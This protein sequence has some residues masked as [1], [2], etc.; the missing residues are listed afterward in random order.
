MAEPGAPENGV[1]A[2]L[3]AALL[4]V[5]VGILAIIGAVLI[6]DP[7]P[8]TAVISPRSALGAL[9][10]SAFFVAIIIPLRR[11]AARR[12]GAIASR[13]G[14]ERT[15][16]V[17]AAGPVKPGLHAAGGPPPRGL[18]GRLTVALTAQAME[19]WGEP[20]ETRYLTIPWGRVRD[21]EIGR[22]IVGTNFYAAVIVRLDGGEGL[23]LILDP[24]GRLGM[25]PTSPE[26]IEPILE[27][28]RRYSSSTGT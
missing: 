10:A 21:A 15:F 1:G 6:G 3:A 19:F 26:A 14:V 2:D 28:I 5:G 11:A 8:G 12:D 22:V 20:G 16:G 17:I 7:A 4:A 9:G 23:P 13:P 27:T 24:G 25:T 18:P